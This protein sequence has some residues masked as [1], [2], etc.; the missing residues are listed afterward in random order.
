[1]GQ[2][3]QVDH[4]IRRT[5]E[6]MR[7]IAFAAAKQ[8]EA[9]KAF[10]ETARQNLDMAWKWRMGY[11]VV[12]EKVAPVF[13]CETPIIV[14]REDLSVCKRKGCPCGSPEWVALEFELHGGAEVNY[15]F[16]P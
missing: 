1:M 4:S 14:L 15:G 11:T 5:V 6:E 13:A 10:N 12:R 3:L 7:S 9:A 2:A 16:E 8:L